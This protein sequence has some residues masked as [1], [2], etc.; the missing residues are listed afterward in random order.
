MKWSTAPSRNLF[1]V[2]YSSNCFATSEIRDCDDLHPSTEFD[3]DS[4]TKLRI[5]EENT[6]YIRINLHAAPR[7]WPMR[8]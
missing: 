3:K 7:A 6:K 2:Y 5:S 8:K 1:I 4:P